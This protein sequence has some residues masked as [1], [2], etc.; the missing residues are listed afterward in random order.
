MHKLFYLFPVLIATSCVENVREQK[1]HTDSVTVEKSVT[2]PAP[3]KQA[4][5][6][7]PEKV[8]AERLNG[9]V[10]LLDTVNGKPIA[11]LHDNILLNAGVAK[12]GWIMA[13]VET[14]IS[15]AQEKAMLFKKGQSLL[16]KGQIVGEALADI[17]LQATG[18]TKGGART[19]LFYGFIPAGKIKAGSVIETALSQ[20]L[21]QHSSRMLPEMQSFIKQF[22]LQPTGFNEPFLEYANYESS[23][24][25][26]SP[27][28]RTVLVF[29][30]N[31]LIAIAD[32][33]HVK[34]PGTAEHKLDRGFHGYFFE[35]ADSKLQ[36]EYIKMFNNFINSVD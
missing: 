10:T 35:D 14:E 9:T 18:Q 16:I 32:S 7:L 13:G 11:R 20:Y 21:L 30:K 3:V 33:R 24:D 19:G 6:A 29:Y 12:G 17:P 36:Q 25:D 15:A 8:I 22:Q 26:P 4:E 28:Y 2:T 1:H 23:V 31:K 5:S 27:A 34:I